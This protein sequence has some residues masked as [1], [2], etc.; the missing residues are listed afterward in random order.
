MLLDKE[1]LTSHLRGEDE[2]KV[3][4]EVLD[5]AELAWK[6]N[7]P[8]VTDFYDPHQQKVAI[9]VLSGIPEVTYFTFGGHR[10][11]ERARLVIVPQFFASD[12]IEPPITVL[13]VEGN[14][15]FQKVS[16]KDFLG[17]MMGTGIKR[18]KIG[19]IIQIENGCQVVIAS[20][21]EKYLLTNLVKV[22]QVPVKVKVIDPE[23]IEVEPER[24]KEIKTTVPAM[25]LDTIAAS[26]FGT[27]RT[28]MVREIKAQK[29]K[30]NWKEVPNPAFN[31]DQGDII[32]IRGRGRVIVDEVKGQ[33]RKGRI[34]IVLKRLI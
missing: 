12:N 13:Q 15:K 1:R 22:H 28:K 24:V 9:S 19:D 29:V 32:S 10:R 30:V 18:E 31:I 5:G 21:V 25:R 14:F 34:S 6:T 7:R 2:H 20:E 11:C 26:G 27:S 3:A 4:I 33:T 17:A 16:H 23:Q 8:Q